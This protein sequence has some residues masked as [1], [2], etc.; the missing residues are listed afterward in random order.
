MFFSLNLENTFKKRILDYDN[1]FLLNNFFFFLCALL[2]FLLKITSILFLSTIDLAVLVLV[3]HRQPDRKLI[4]KLRPLTDQLP[5]WK[6]KHYLQSQLTI[7][8]FRHKPLLLMLRH[9]L[10]QHLPS[11]RL[12]QTIVPVDILPQLD[13][14]RLVNR[15]ALH[16]VVQHS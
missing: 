14:F 3:L 8:G 16:I 6:I 2:F 5:A 7:K 9:T 4:V 1:K 10:E 15:Q 12:E 11:P 13:Q